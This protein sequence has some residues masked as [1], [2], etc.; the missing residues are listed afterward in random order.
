MEL[1]VLRVLCVV[2]WLLVGWL[3]RQFVRSRNLLFGDLVVDETSS[4]VFLHCPHQPEELLEH[5]YIMLKIINFNKAYTR[6]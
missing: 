5:E 2:G 6:K 1:W 3:F 4:E